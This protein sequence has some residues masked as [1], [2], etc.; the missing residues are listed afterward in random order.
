MS[1]LKKAAHFHEQFLLPLL[2][3]YEQDYSCSRE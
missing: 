2:R 1:H 3:Y